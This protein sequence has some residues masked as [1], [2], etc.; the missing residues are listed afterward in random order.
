ML[1]YK[2][3]CILYLHSHQEYIVEGEEY[4][5]M[6]FYVSGSKQQATAHLDVKKVFL[7]FPILICMLY[8]ATECQRQV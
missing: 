3:V 8:N 1:H 5:R 2:L 7:M 6:Q 4:M